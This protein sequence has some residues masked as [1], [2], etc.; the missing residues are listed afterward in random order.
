MTAFEN[1]TQKHFPFALTQVT[2]TATSSD[3][4]EIEDYSQA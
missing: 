1:F 4:I 3:G 2:A